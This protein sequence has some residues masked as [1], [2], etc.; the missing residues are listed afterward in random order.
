[1]LESI[2]FVREITEL[3]SYVMQYDVLYV[4]NAQG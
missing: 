4:Y 1:M 2:R 3:E